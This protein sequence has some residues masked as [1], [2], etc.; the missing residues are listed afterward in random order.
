MGNPS[1]PIERMRWGIWGPAR[2]IYFIVAVR[3]GRVGGIPQFPQ[4]MENESLCRKTAGNRLV[5]RRFKPLKSCGWVI[6]PKTGPP[7]LDQKPQG[8]DPQQPNRVVGAANPY[9]GTT[10]GHK[11]GWPLIPAQ[12]VASFRF[13]KLADPE[14]KPLHLCPARGFFQVCEVMGPSV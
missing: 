14:R 3:I 13:V 6:T 7:R 8:L 9:C 12:P 1:P 11:R 5:L 4:V 2:G 10:C